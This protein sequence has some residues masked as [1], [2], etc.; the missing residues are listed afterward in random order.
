MKKNKENRNIK[1]KV[2]REKERDTNLTVLGK[3]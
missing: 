2:E 1:Q 3:W